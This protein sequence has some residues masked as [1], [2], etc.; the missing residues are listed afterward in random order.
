MGV[1]R[2]HETAAGT[3]FTTLLNRV[4]QTAGNPIGYTDAGFDN[5]T[6]TDQGS[7]PNIHAYGGNGGNQLSSATY[8]LD[9]TGSSPSFS[10]F[11]GLDPSGDWSLFVADLSGNHVITLESWGLDITAVPEPTTWAGIFFGI[12]FCGTQ[13]VRRF[14][15]G[16][17]ARES[18]CRVCLG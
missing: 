18:L 5:F 12:L 9:S 4:G 14:R 7:Y 15:A 16:P 11:Y 6:L 10:S 17:A 1:Y 13:V 2:R 8:L 3:G